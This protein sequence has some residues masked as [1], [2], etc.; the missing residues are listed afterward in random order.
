MKERKSYAYFEAGLIAW[1]KEWKRARHLYHS[2]E[3]A[4]IIGPWRCLSRQPFPGTLLEMSTDG[5]WI[6]LAVGVQPSL[7]DAQTA[8]MLKWQMFPHLLKPECIAMTSRYRLSDV[9]WAVWQSS[10]LLK[11]GSEQ[12]GRCDAEE[13]SLRLFVCLFVGVSSTIAK[14]VRRLFFPNNLDA[15]LPMQ[16][17]EGWG[18]LCII[19]SQYT[20]MLQRQWSN[21]TV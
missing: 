20:A 3:G 12:V 4:L 13:K 1:K 5:N 9:V 18:S 16:S 10:G 17:K 11:S 8:E 7:T 21:V 2:N 6:H 15:F 14:V 19:I